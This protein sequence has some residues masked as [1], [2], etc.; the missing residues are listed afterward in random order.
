MTRDPDQ[1]TYVLGTEVTLTPVPN[2]G[3]AFTGWSGDV[4]A[5]H[6]MDNPLLVTM[7]QDR[8]ITASFTDPNA[9]AADD[10]NRANETPLV[11]G[12][13]WQRAVVS[14]GGTVNLANQHVVGTTGDA[15]YYWQGQE[16][17]TTRG[18]S[19]GPR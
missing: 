13:N 11:V 8:T 5:G 2:G 1:P 12:G 7:D 3:Y 10:F 6:E 18:S 16:P 15:L 19:R 17:S 9:I 4:P 14:G